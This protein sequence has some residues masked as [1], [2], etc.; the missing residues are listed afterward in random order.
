MHAPKKMERR[1][2]VYNWNKKVWWARQAARTAAI[3]LNREE[4]TIWKWKG[5]AEREDFGEFSIQGGGKHRREVG[6]CRSSI[7][8]FSATPNDIAFY[9]IIKLIIMVQ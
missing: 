5:F 4:C 7:T 9:L 6:R 8:V 2:P 3:L 1:T